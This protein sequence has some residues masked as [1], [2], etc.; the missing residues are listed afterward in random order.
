MFIGYLDFLVCKIPVQFCPVFIYFL[1]WT[2]C[3]LLVFQS[4]LF[5]L[6]TDPLHM[7]VAN[8]YFHI[9]VCLFTL[10]M[11]SF[12]EQKFFILMESN[13]LVFSLWLVLFVSC[14]KTL[15]PPLGQEDILV[16]FSKILIDLKRSMIMSKIHCSWP[17]P[18]H[19]K[20]I[21]GLATFFC[22]VLNFYLCWLPLSLWR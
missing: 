19:Y 4:S 21:F 20:S 10:F 17:H 3:L 11:V 14:F 15:F 18:C 2:L 16:L 1:N 12:N 9:V 7:Y 5:T 6:D 22:S 8:V 13:L